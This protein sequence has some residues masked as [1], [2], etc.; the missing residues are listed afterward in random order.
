M[1]AD[2]T[3]QID[4]LTR[5]RAMRL[6]LYPQWVKSGKITEAQSEKATHALD[7]AIETLVGM[8]AAG[9]ITDATYGADEAP[10]ELAVRVAGKTY[11]Y[12]RKHEA[13]DSPDK[14]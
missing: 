3:A 10:M 7:A 5:E 13:T 1:A 14:T 2:L 4:E 12:A 11:N 9:Q 8:R 6:R